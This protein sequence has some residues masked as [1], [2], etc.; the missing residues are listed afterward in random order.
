MNE[1]QVLIDHCR[2]H[3]QATLRGIWPGRGKNPTE[4]R[5]KVKTLFGD[6][7]EV[8]EDKIVDG[9]TIRETVATIIFDK[10]KG[11]YRSI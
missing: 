6:K 8:K 5:A 3:S 10:Q 9:E 4:T 1:L 11:V 7:Q 2:K